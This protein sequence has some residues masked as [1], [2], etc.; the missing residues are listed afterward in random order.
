MVTRL[1]SKPLTHTPVVAFGG[2][3]SKYITAILGP[4]IYELKIPIKHGW[5][6]DE[7]KTETFMIKAYPSSI[8]RSIQKSLL[9]EL[10]D[11]EGKSPLH[12]SATTSRNWC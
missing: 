11:I 5:I 10:G 9:F 12:R 6:L 3:E 8:T 7:L 4:A 1:A 2:H